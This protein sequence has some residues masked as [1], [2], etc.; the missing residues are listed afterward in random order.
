[1]ARTFTR[2]RGRLGA[3]RKTLW[4]GI[5]PTSITLASASAVAIQNSLNAAA[6]ALTPFTI[7]RTRGFWQLRSD[8][9]AASE[10]Y[11]AS[12]A[13]AVV[14]EQAVAIGATA[15]PTPDTDISSSM[16]FMFESMASRFE[17]DDATGFHPANGV[18]QHYDSKAMRKVEQGEDVIFVA[19]A[20][21]IVASAKIVHVA[22]MLV[23][24]N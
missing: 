4:L 6:L 7:I 9:S 22:R 24:T 12:I 20:L 3:P 16:F 2:S 13:A 14:S 8:Q 17:F 23:K 5:A 10:D 11:G 19:E 21:S 15:V 18:R 1:M